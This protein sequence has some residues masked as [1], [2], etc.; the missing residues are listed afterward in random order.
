MHGEHVDALIQCLTVQC[1]RD[2]RDA[3]DFRDDACKVATS[4]A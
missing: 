3:V 2:R 4:Y 1:K